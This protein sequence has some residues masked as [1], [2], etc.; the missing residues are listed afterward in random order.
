MLLWY[1]LTQR[2]LI[3]M[4]ETVCQFVNINSYSP[5]LF[6]IWTD[7]AQIYLI[8]GLI[9]R[10]WKDLSYVTKL[11]PNLRHLFY[12]KMVCFLWIEM[13]SEHCFITCLLIY[14]VLFQTCSFAGF[15]YTYLL[16]Y[17]IH[18]LFVYLLLLQIDVL[19]AFKL[20]YQNNVLFAYLL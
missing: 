5:D 12:I 13:V 15:F 8:F 3:K 10:I 19:F 7:I 1:K 9:F 18:V 4:K 14:C 6:D 20:L 16:F 17:R 11:K 2:I